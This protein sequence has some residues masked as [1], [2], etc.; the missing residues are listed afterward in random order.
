MKPVSLADISYEQGLQLLALRKQA[1]DSGKIRRMSKEAMDNSYPLQRIGTQVLYSVKEAD[2]LGDFKDSASG[3][4]SS[5]TDGLGSAGGQIQKNLGSAASGVEGWWGGLGKPT[6]NV[7]KDG[8][9]GAGL[10]AGAG[11]GTSLYRGEGNH[12][13]NTLMGGVAGGALGG[14]LGVFNNPEVADKIQSGISGLTDSLTGESKK[15]PAEP[16][17]SKPKP[18]NAKDE[19]ERLNKLPADLRSRELMDLT[20]DEQSNMPEYLHGTGAATEVG[21][22]GF[23]ARKINQMSRYSPTALADT[24]LSGHAKPKAVSNELKLKWDK[25]KWERMRGTAKGARKVEAAI[26]ANPKLRT[27]IFGNVKQTAALKSLVGKNRG[28]AESVGTK[29]RYIRRT[30]MGGVALATGYGLWKTLKSYM[31]AQR[32][33]AN[34]KYILHKYVNDNPTG[35]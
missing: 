16:G 31:E 14:G 24:V 28:L 20:T 15:T 13:R 6:K 25:A 4:I 5:V 29:G 10:G 7:L 27:N 33:R 12:G 2:S 30:G 18:F 22:G 1:M 19:V 3:L 32:H 35:Q 34:A 8:L 23:A 21:I 26:R 17:T 9:L 11:L